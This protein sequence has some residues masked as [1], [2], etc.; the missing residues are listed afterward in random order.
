MLTI[1]SNISLLPYTT[2]RIDV[3][4]KYF[5]EIHSE[6]DFKELFSSPIFQQEKK[7]ILGGGAKTFF[8]KDFDGLVIKIDIKGIQL[9]KETDNQLHICAGAGEDWSDFVNFCNTHNRAGIENLIAIPGNVGTAPFSNIGAYGVEIGNLVE[10]VEGYDMTTGERKTYTHEQCQFGYRTSIFKSA[11]KNQFLITA[12]GFVLQ[13]FDDSYLF[14]TNYPDVQAFLQNR[15]PGSLTEISEI[16]ASIRSKKL[17]DVKKTGTVGSF[18]VNP[19]VC[20]EH[21]LALQ[22]A[23]PEMPFY[24]VPDTTEV[25]KL[26]AGR[27][28]EKAGLKG[29]STGKV[30]TF[31]QNA[32]AIVNEGGTAGEVLAV[33]DYIQQTVKEKF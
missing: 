21:F 16:I 18:F 11:L 12:V 25:T 20:Q 30:G 9:E 28:I 13:K 33:V 4:T 6:S 22:K 14:I 23:Y 31:P 10:R 2:F 17:P 32:L 7:Q 27:L 26:S 5:T 8:T 15:K 19:F 1:Q 24:P 29:Y 3:Q